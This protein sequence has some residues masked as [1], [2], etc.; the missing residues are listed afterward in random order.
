M[1]GQSSIEACYPVGPVTD[2][3]PAE[4]RPGCQV[5]TTPPR[6]LYFVG[7]ELGEGRPGCAVWK[8]NKFAKGVH[9]NPPKRVILGGK[10][11]F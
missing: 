11:N 7:G 6:G 1:L 5:A 9:V 8:Q 3:A 4:V 2:C 10:K